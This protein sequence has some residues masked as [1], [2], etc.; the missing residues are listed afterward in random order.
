MCETLLPRKNVFPHVR[1]QYHVL[2]VHMADAGVPS[3]WFS[4]VNTARA[5]Q[6]LRSYQSPFNPDA[7]KA[8][9]GRTFCKPWLP[10]LMS[11]GQSPLSFLR[12]ETTKYQLWQ[13]KEL[14]REL[15]LCLSLSTNNTLPPCSMQC[16]TLCSCQRQNCETHPLSVRW[17]G[18]PR[19]E[20]ASFTL[21]AK[22]S[23]VCFAG[24]IQ[25]SSSERRR[26]VVGSLLLRCLIS[27][28]SIINRIST[29]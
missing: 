20:K 18:R 12:R 26:I 25:T 19:R 29:P 17:G 3:P 28:S 22:P 1:H 7:K 11:H 13:V 2:S 6:T 14:D 15:S 8:F 9:D 24:L 16:Q 4:V 21:K 10:C 5:R 27:N 23:N